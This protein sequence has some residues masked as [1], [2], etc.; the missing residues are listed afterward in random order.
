MRSYGRLAAAAAAL[1]MMAVA[2]TTALGDGTETLGPPSLP[3]AN[4]SAA[5]IAG[6]GMKDHPDTP[7]SFTFQVPAG[8]TVKQVLAYWHGHTT[9]SATPDRP[10][11]NISLNNRSVDGKLIGG[12]SNFYLGELFWT[13]RADVTGLNL[14]SA[15]SNTVTVSDMHFESSALPPSGNEGAALVVIYDLPG[16]TSKLVGVRDGNDLAYAGFSGNFQRTVPQSFNFTASP[17]PR[18]ASLGLLV[19][20][21]YGPLSEGVYGNVIKGTFNT[22]ETFSIV[23]SLASNEGWQLDAAN[24]PVTVP[25]N[26]TSV[27][28]EIRS[29][30]GDTPGS[31]TWTAATLSIDGDNTP[32]T[33]EPCTLGGTNT[34]WQAWMQWWKTYLTAKFGVRYAN[35]FMSYFDGGDCAASDGDA[36]QPRKTIFGFYWHRKDCQPPADMCRNPKTLMELIKFLRW[37]NGWCRK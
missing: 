3:V 19:G 28:V 2:P 35:K 22:G 15:G 23:N 24:F 6:V 29:E 9:S 21:A 18:A 12:P 1:A 17:K 8:A 27:S 11:T 33:E 31:I 10:D 14:V 26:A 30:G 20:S 34:K 32:P 37:G 36:C 13:Y 25:P 16:S 5:L 4:G 7:A